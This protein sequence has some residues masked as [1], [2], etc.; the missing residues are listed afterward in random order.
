MTTEEA[1]RIL[2][3][4]TTKE[5]LTNYSKEET[6]SLVEKACFIACECMGK[7]IPKKPI[8][9]VEKIIGF[10]LCS[11]CKS[12]IGTTIMVYEPSCCPKCGQAL[13]WKLEEHQKAIPTE[14]F[15][16]RFNKV[17]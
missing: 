13:D 17:I 10:Y 1:I 14:H 5:A 7:Q 2:N 15:T 8:K 9:T 16:E 11:N 12:K 3:P 6:I 4:Y